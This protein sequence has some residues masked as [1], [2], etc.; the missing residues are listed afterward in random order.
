MTHRQAPNRCRSI[1]CGHM[2]HRT[3]RNEGN[4]G[5]GG[6]VRYYA[7]RGE[8]PNFGDELNHFLLPRILDGFFDGKDDPLFLGIGSILFDH[9]PAHLTK[10]VVGAGYGG[11]M[12]KPVLDDRWKVYAVRGPR[13]ARALGLDQRLVAADLA[14]LQIGRA[15]V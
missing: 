12:A 3:F 5:E 4:G 7:Y 15:H 9:H 2:R 1:A 11:Y 8:E 13:T 6:L 10:I 14:V